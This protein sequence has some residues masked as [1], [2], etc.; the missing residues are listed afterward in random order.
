MSNCNFGDN[1]VFLILITEV[2]LA[3][4]SYLVTLNLSKPCVREFHTL[5]AIV[6]NFTFWKLLTAL[7]LVWAV[8][9]IASLVIWTLRSV[10]LNP[11]IKTINHAGVIPADLKDWE[12]WHTKRGAINCHAWAPC[13]A[14]PVP[15]IIDQ[16]TEWLFHS[17]GAKSSSLFLCRVE[18]GCQRIFW[19]IYFLCVLFWQ[20]KKHH[21]NKWHW[22]K[23]LDGSLRCWLRRATHTRTA[24]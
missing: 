7:L 6:L 20:Q 13:R 5:V 16:C 18:L 3:Q 22:R 15:V 14:R 4:N 19:M 1:L 2:C 10:K 17:K 21:L 9:K 24:K 23:E 11:D 12:G 8:I